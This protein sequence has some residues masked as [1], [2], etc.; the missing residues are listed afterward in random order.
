MKG[1]DAIPF[2]PAEHT[3]QGLVSTKLLFK[4]ILISYMCEIISIF[5]LRDIFN[6]IVNIFHILI[7]Y[8]I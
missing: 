6:Y 4:S 8:I 3:W 7:N 2:L 5:N 1:I